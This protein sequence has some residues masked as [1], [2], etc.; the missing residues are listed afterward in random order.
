MK[1]WK[2]TISGLVGGLPMILSVFGVTIPEP[3][4]NLILA[5]GVVFAT[6]FAKDKNVTGM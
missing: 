1:N 4:I 5:I 3:V 2:T 6:Y